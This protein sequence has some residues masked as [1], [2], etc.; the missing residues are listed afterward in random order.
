MAGKTCAICGKP[1][2]MYPLCKD[3]FTLR[4]KGEIIQC[5]KCKTWHKK[6]EKCIGCEIRNKEK[7]TFSTQIVK[8]TECITCSNKAIYNGCFCPTCFKE[9]QILK[10][11]ITHLNTQYQAKEYYY[12]LKNSIFWMNKIES[13]KD[14]CKKLYAIAEI[15]DEFKN[16]KQK[17]VA[18]K[19]IQYLLTKKEE[20]LNKNN[21]TN[22]ESSIEEIS[23][24]IE[25][26]E[27]PEM[28]PETADFRRMFPATIR[29][30]DGHYVRS[31]NEKIIDDRLYAKKVFHE[32]ETRYKA[33]DGQAYYPDFYIPA[34]DLYIEYFGMSEKKEKNKAKKELFLKDK[35]HT[36]EFIE[37]KYQGGV[38]EEKIDDIIDKYDLNKKN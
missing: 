29:C 24:V 16:I 32:Y 8:E 11:D 28:D 26:D 3:C 7:N 10:K 31:N 20:Y 1:S 2:G 12:N 6:N 17:E 5:P 14:A 18:S 15:I 23:T 27:I 34:V 36:F 30:H 13:A 21:T 25:H 38:L 9:M 19:D 22:N 33:T 35:K 37:S 4:D